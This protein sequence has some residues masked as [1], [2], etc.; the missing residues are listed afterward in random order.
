MERCDKTIFSILERG[1]GGDVKTVMEKR[2][3]G[4]EK[5]VGLVRPSTKMEKANGLSP[6]E[7]PSLCA[8][9]EQSVSP[10]PLPSDSAHKEVNTTGEGP[11]SHG[12]SGPR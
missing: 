3:L 4:G 10:Q 2:G 6:P 5:G 7:S 11:G 8:Q 12:S 1:R 9:E